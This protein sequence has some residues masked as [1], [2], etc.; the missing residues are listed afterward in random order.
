LTM[1]AGRRAFDLKYGNRAMWR[2]LVA[3]F[4]YSLFGTFPGS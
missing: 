1:I 4:R 2:R 3:A